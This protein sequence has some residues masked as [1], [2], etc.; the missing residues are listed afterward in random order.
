MNLE[1]LSPQQAAV[2]SATGSPI[3]VL[4][5]AGTGKTTAA[6][7]AAHAAI[8]RGEIGA[9]QKVLFLTFSRTAVTQIAARARGRLGGV[10]QDI[11]I[12]TFHAFSFR[13]LQDFGRYSG[14]GPS[15]PK[16]QSAARN[17][18]MGAD[19][20]VYS[21]DEL[22]PRAIRVLEGE[23]ISAIVARR[24]PLVICD[25]FQDTSTDQLQ[26]LD[27][28]ANHARQILLAD[29]NQMIYTFVPGVSPERLENAR[30]RAQTVIDLQPDSY[31]DPSGCIPAMAEAIRQRN[32]SSPE[33]SRAIEL[34]AL[35]VRSDVPDDSV[36]DEL[37]Y[38]LGVARELGMS[39]VGIFAHSNESVAGLGTQLTNHGVEHSLVGLPEAQGEALA[40][41]SALVEFGAGNRD[42][43]GLHQ[44]L[45]TF[46]TA[47]T[48]GRRPPDVASGLAFGE[49]ALPAAFFVR[50]QDIEESLVR[51]SDEGLEALIK[52][53]CGAWQRLAL[54]SGNRP[55]QVSAQRFAAIAQRVAGS[56]E[57]KAVLIERLVAQ[58]DRERTAVLV[59]NDY[60]EQHPVQIMNFHQ[61]K[62]REVDQVILIYRSGD[63]LADHRAGEPFVEASRVLYVA[64]TRARKR[65]VVVLP[66][67]PHDLVAPL[68]S[69]S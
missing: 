37:D 2:A 1:D 34:N 55:W 19:P 64:L 33:I 23:A 35:A 24:W 51:S 18:L 5:G 36:M 46:L 60:L 48:R 50:L 27:L 54:G 49:P 30:Q 57:P 67:E 47:C 26:L 4:G 53:A 25:E 13:I 14:F 20:T 17:K 58:V 59:G 42:A 3:L 44:A 40:A 56:G 9:H 45:A 61:T 11:E 52:T 66:P 16:V 21:Y 7:W 31:R 15:L 69:L 12:S 29:P 68:A 28:L 43:S 62:G 63:Y 65:V 10:R 41:L 22:I 39:S 38:E 32:F 6:L 8:E